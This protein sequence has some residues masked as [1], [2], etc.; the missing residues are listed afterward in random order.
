MGR[1]SRVSECEGSGLHCEGGTLGL[2]RSSSCGF[3]SLKW[4]PRKAES[5]EASGSYEQC[6]NDLV[7]G[8]LVPALI[9][10]CRL[11]REVCTSQN[12]GLQISLEGRK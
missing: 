7:S 8:S 4:N 11:Q 1:A 12:G 10:G 9:P 6:L 2:P 3:L 5:R